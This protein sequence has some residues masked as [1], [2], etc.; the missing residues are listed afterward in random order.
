MIPLK[1]T[2]FTLIE[3]MIVISIILILS[4]LGISSYRSVRASLVLDM[5]ADK[6]VLLLQGFEAQTRVSSNSQGARCIR[7]VFDPEKSP[8]Q[9]TAIYRNAVQGCDWDKATVSNIALSED[10]AIENRVVVSF[11]PPRGQIQVDVSS[12]GRSVAPAGTFDLQKTALILSLKRNPE[13][14]RHVVLNQISGTIQ[15]IKP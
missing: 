1:K 2:G 15:K 14:I 6:L 10:V 8:Q 11:I 7:A 12:L 9:Y 13:T 4:T 3:L 5:E